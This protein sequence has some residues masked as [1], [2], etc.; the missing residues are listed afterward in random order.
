MCISSNEYTGRNMRIDLTKLEYTKTYE[1]EQEE[2]LM[3]ATAEAYLESLG[4]KVKTE[5]GDYR[6]TWYILK[7][8]GTWLSKNDKYTL[9]ADYLVR[10][11][12]IDTI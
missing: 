6:N 10:A 9:P 1:E 11:V 2:Q 5:Y 3:A 12:K 8:F 7:D 4:I